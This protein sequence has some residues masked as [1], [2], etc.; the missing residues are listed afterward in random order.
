MNTHPDVSDESADTATISDDGSRSLHAK[1]P[2]WPIPAQLNLFIAAVQLL[3]L[4][5]LLLIAGRVSFW[6]WVPVLALGYA[7]L[8]NS[9]YLMLH[10]AEHALLHPNR[11]VNDA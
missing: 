2:P 10:E 5:A 1:A 7:L 9:A 6:P 8:M 4:S 11:H 3:A